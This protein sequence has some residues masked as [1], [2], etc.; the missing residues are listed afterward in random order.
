MEVGLD[1]YHG[2][3]STGISAI[4]PGV[5]NT[6]G[7]TRRLQQPPARRSSWSPSDLERHA[8]N[9]R[10]RPGLD[11]VRPRRPDLCIKHSLKRPGYHQSSLR[12]VPAEQLTTLA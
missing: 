12:D 1:D 5:S 11:Q 10:F 7:Q 8:K 3:S 4:T 9:A 6:A 2:H